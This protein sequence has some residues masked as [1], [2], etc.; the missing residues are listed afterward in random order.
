VAEML[1]ALDERWDKLPEVEIE[2][3]RQARMAAR[4]RLY[5]YRS[6]LGFG[7]WGLGFGLRGGDSTATGRLLEPHIC[8]KRSK[9]TMKLW[10]FGGIHTPSPPQICG[11]WH[12]TV[13]GH[14]T[15][16]SVVGHCRSVVER[17]K[18]CRRSLQM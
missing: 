10:M 6:G 2:G 8:S 5:G 16:R 1:I 4:R 17:A 9:N 12:S 14:H 18:I 11:E 7:V 13:V 15:G 3:R